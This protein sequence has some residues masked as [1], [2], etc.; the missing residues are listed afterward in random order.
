MVEEP[1][2]DLAPSVAGDC[3]VV[4]R[5]EAKVAISSGVTFDIGIV[6]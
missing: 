3:V 6:D 4:G 1:T 2:A 5:K